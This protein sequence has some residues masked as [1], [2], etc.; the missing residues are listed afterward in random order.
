LSVLLLGVVLSSCSSAPGPSATL[1]RYLT[2]WSDGNY[3]AM[4]ALVLHPPA[5][6][7]TF[8]RQVAAELDLEHAHYAA[9]PA[10]VQGSAATA[11]VTGHLVLTP[12]GPWTVHSTL[13]LRALDNGWKVAWSPASIIPELPPGDQLSTTVSWPPRAPITG[14][15]GAL[16]TVR[17]PQ[18]TVGVE[19]SRITSTATVTAALEQAGA[20]P[21]Q[22]SGALSTATAHPQW[23]VPV[24][25]VTQARYAQIKPAIYPVPGTVFQTH[26]A[27]GAATAGLAA[28]VVG[29]VG[30]ITAQEL[31]RLGPPYQANDTI[32]QSGLEQA[33][34]RRLAGRPGG[35]IEVVTASGASVTTVARFAAHGGR[36]VATTIDP[37]IQGAAEAALAGVTQPAALVAIQAST[38]KVLAS[39]SDPTSD[40]FDNALTGSFPPGST[41][42]IVTSA[43][44]IEH[45]AS[46]SSPAHCP[47]TITVDG[48]TF[49][50]F[51]GEAR[52][53][54]TLDQAFAQSCNAAFI[55]LAGALPDNS[56]T[57]TAAQFGIGDSFSMGISAFGGKVPTPDSDAQRAATSIGQANV[58]VSPLAM[59][60]AAAAVDSGRLHEPRLVVG[61]A[62]DRAP[63]HA[64]NAT[65][66]SDL[67]TMMAAVVNS[68]EGT[69]A[70]AGL[71]V[72]TFGKTGTA[73]FGTA[74][75]L[76]THAWF[77]GYRGDLA[78]AVLVVGGGIGG[79]VAAPLATKFLDAVPS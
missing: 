4:A 50:N 14:A 34:E 55:G 27:R 76:Q 19:G 66:V 53:S 51:E 11:A 25:D 31:S 17:S 46:P 78:F 39:V 60:T 52:P 37:T 18:V 71:P 8:N 1:T 7:V 23:F 16:L 74:K 15:D 69:A 28:H 45:G 58:L 70:D 54:L 73:E 3:R 72:G 20:T 10:V 38:G 22:V 24:F 68:P 64:L 79:A 12:F 56:F 65:V 61:A 35:H 62:D 32:G 13:H 67:R 77:I 36:P 47:A 63:V 42:K 43:D 6:F 49:H 21:A 40:A 30:P 9:R 29:S 59:A 26:S 75:P 41:F 44:L 48:Q 2:A 33:D 57:A 5:D